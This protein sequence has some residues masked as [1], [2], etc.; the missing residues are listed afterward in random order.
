MYCLYC[1]WTIYQKQRKNSEL[2]KNAK[3]YKKSRKLATKAELEA[4]IDKIAK[5]QAF[6]S[7]YFCDRNDFEDDATQNYLIFQPM[8]KYF[9]KIGNTDNISVQKS[10][11]LSD[12]SIKPASTS[13]NSVA[14]SLSYIGAKPRLIL[15]EVV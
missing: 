12:E 15:L 6:D 14:P 2:V 9:K 8:Y 3:L 11:G 13:D 5:L 1:L 4:K 10:K 7:S